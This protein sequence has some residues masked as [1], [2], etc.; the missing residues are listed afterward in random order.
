MILILRFCFEVI[1]FVMNNLLGIR[2]PVIREF[3]VIIG[4]IIFLTFY[5]IAGIINWVYSIR[6]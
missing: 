3:I 4:N 5:G 1:D 6:L 2:I